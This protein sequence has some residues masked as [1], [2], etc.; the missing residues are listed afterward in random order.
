MSKNHV[1]LRASGT[2]ATVFDSLVGKLCRFSERRCFHSS[3]DLISSVGVVSVCPLYRG[4]DKLARRRVA[5][6]HNSI[7]ELLAGRVE[8]RRRD[9]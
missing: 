3:C 6:V 9:F 7:F 2:R 1:S 4:G 8:P 5:P